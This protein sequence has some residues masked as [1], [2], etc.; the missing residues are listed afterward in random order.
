MFSA[1]IKLL[2]HLCKNRSG[3]L[4]YGVGAGVILAALLVSSG[5][6]QSTSAN[7]PSKR[8]PV[9]VTVATVTQ[10]TIPIQ[11]RTI[12]NVEAYS[13]ISVKALIGGELTKVH[14][15]E[16]DFVTNRQLLFEIDRRPYE[17]AVRQAEAN[18]ARDAANLANAEAE[19]RRFA[20]RSEE[21]T[22]E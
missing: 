4:F 1:R 6:K 11:V 10:R 3:D 17:E 18:L 15:T 21:H 16:G 9:P 13:T 19:A 12:G 14:F 5:C 7:T 8:P 20:V 22:S 2:P